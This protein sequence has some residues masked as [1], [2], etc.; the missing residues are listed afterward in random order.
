MRI[1]NFGEQFDAVALPAAQA[2]G[3]PLAHPVDGQDGRAVEGRGIECAGG[4][5]HMVLGK[6]HTLAF[7]ERADGVEHMLF[8]PHFVAQ[9]LRGGS[10]E[11]ATPGGT[12]RQ[13]VF[14]HTVECG[15]R[16]VIKHD[17]VQ[18]V[19]VDKAFLQAVV[20]GVDGKGRVMFFTRE[21]FLL[22]CCDYH[23]AAHQCGRRVMVKR[24]N[25]EYQFGHGQSFLIRWSAGAGRPA[26]ARASR[27]WR[28]GPA[29]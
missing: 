20:D 8:H 16:I 11:L 7:A 15:D 24:R 27:Q 14:N 19:G 12:C 9:H 5:R 29:A 2:G 10:D 3:S 26:P 25:A 18:F 13:C 1:V 4:V 22:C 23:A 17:R 6:Q 28:G 21:S